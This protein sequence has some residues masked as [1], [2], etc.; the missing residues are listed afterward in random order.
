MKFFTVNTNSQIE[1]L[2]E[3]EINLIK[4]LPKFSII[5]LP[6]T[7]LKEGV[8]RIRSALISQ[9]FEIPKNREVVIN[10][11]PSNFRKLNQN[12]ELAIII[13]FLCVTK[14]IVI[15]EAKLDDSLLILGEL[16]LKGNVTL[17]Q[18]SNSH[19]IKT[20]SGKILAG[21]TDQPLLFD[22]YSL[23]NISD[24][25]NQKVVFKPKP[26]NSN[27]FKRPPFQTS[28][29]WSR[30]E[31][32][33]LSLLA[34]G[35]FSALLAGPHGSGKTT[36]AK[37]VWKLLK[38]PES[39]I[40]KSL[41]RPLVAPHHSI[42]K[43]SLIGGGTPLRQGELAK[44]HGGVLILDEF[45][46]F[47]RESLEVLREAIENDEVEIS[48]L[49]QSQKYK[50]DFITLATTNLCPCGRWTGRPQDFV[51]CS[52]TLQSCKSYRN[53]LLG[54]LVDR[55]SVLWVKGYRQDNRAQ[56][57]GLKEILNQ[58]TKAQ[59]FQLGYAKSQKLCT[60]LELKEIWPT[61]KYPWLMDI[62][63]FA[64]VSERR[65]LAFWRVSRALADL[66][67]SE[68]VT[69]EHLREA[70]DWTCLDFRTLA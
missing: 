44:A 40:D 43:I 65:K 36:L 52:K 9:G 5:G 30:D 26:K 22:Y 27:L 54:P 10:L 19:F 4:G 21:S 42:P 59:E 61:L 48:R 31:A 55:F 15:A 39:F 64:G 45:L 68:K 38:P 23:K 51:S 41:W 2:I 28:L 14:Q 32:R 3:I 35:E 24:L 1:S 37:E 62:Y 29:L 12:V 8:L 53:K 34:Y 6:D 57:I 69:E 33:L 49:G 11:K 25:K 50:T 16:D 18:I 7:A 13:C 47:K 60:K 56:K 58:I 20:W 17:D 63:S 70:Y 66:D 46:E 67:L